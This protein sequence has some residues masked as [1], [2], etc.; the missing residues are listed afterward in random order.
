MTISYDPLLTSWTLIREASD[1]DAVARNRFS[2]CYEDVVRAYLVTR[3]QR[4]GLV[5]RVDDA[6]QDVFVECFRTGGLLDR[7]DSSRPGGFR[8]FLFGAVRNVAL[9]Q[10]K[11]AAKEWAKRLPAT[12]FLSIEPAREVE[13]TRAFDRAWAESILQ[14][15]RVLQEHRARSSGPDAQRRIELLQLR[16]LEGLSVREIAERWGEEHG[17]TKRAYAKA[18]EEFRSCLREVV[19]LHEADAVDLDAECRAIL[20]LLQ[21]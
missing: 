12:E 2:E 19:A 8:A 21:E 5:D 11:T 15:A 10:E 17:R 3:W 1:G 9:R 16:F 7:V 14:Q 4:S 6:V 18:R 13:L 20:A